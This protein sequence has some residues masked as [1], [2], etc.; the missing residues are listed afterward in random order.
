MSAAIGHEQVFVTVRFRHAEAVA[1]VAI[2]AAD[3]C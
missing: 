3:G 2:Q 1:A